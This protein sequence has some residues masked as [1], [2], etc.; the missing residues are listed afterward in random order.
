MAKA[1]ER[2]SLEK[3]KAQLDQ[4]IY[5]GEIS[6]NPD[7]IVRIKDSIKQFQEVILKVNL[8]GGPH[9][10]YGSLSGLSHDL[11]LYFFSD[12]PSNPFISSTSS[13]RKRELC[14]TQIDSEKDNLFI[15]IS[16]NQPLKT[17][18]DLTFKLD[19][20][21]Y[22]TG[23]NPYLATPNDPFYGRQWYLFNGAGQNVDS[24]LAFLN[25]DI[26]A[27]E[28]WMLH[29]GSRSTPIAV[30]D[31][32]ID[33][34]HPDLKN[35]IWINKDEI[36]ANNIDDD[37]NG[38]VD[39]VHGWDFITNQPDGRYRE[40]MQQNIR[41][42]GTHVA[43][44]IGAEGDNEIGITGINWKSQLMSLNV[45]DDAGQASDRDIINA[46]DYAI[47]NGAKVIN[48]SLGEESKIGIGQ[49]DSKKLESSYLKVNNMYREIFRKARNND[50]LIVMAAGNAG[51]PGSE[52]RRW[53]RVGDL[54][55]NAIFPYS[56]AEKKDNLILVTS[57]DSDAKIA[58]YANYGNKV[59]DIA[60]PGGNIQKASFKTDPT[61]G[62][63]VDVV[64][65]N[66]GI[67][68]TVPDQ[69]IGSNQTKRG[70]YMMK[71]GTSM[72]APVI[73]GAAA[74]LWDYYPDLDASDIKKILI[75][76]AFK[77]DSL[78]PFVVKSRALNLQGAMDKV[79]K[80]KTK[81]DALIPA[82]GSKNEHKA[83]VNCKK[84]S[85]NYMSSLQSTI[86]KGSPGKDLF[87]LNDMATFS[88]QNSDKIINFNPAQSDQL[89]LP[90]KRF[91]GLSN[92]RVTL[93][94]VES[95]EAIIEAAKQ[96]VDII[97]FKKSGQ[98]FYNGN[99]DNPRFGGE[100]IGGL[101]VEIKN[102]PDLTPNDFAVVNDPSAT[103]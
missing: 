69:T 24:E 2:M 98:L 23:Q 13:G 102:A 31:S 79:D 54:N 76:N 77:I 96:P 21:V 46:L 15:R 84:N 28:A 41:S 12:K 71:N 7:A 66:Y 80:M 18:K 11:D 103:L 49:V 64:V 38:F 51:S 73:A 87:I 101:F 83:V 75:N 22:P 34:E 70:A 88:Q 39:D 61:T 56:F 8:S 1:I 4:S 82:I 37:S 45:F 93:Q 42:H 40:S 30:I 60:A 50:V 29:R 100:Q 74:L 32:G 25:F 81:Y 20:D 10:V 68:S 57:V 97:Y 36:P 47:N 85:C 6:A 91:K 9:D 86:L 33:L 5:Y 43:G 3:L 16:S 62:Q 53:H 99:G 72:A 17:T 58:P 95:T 19:L 52:T 26:A 65:S 94:T 44:I 14:F 90:S 48:L 78:E 89:V 92:D 63:I 67:Y 55:L 59:V 35:N 27:P